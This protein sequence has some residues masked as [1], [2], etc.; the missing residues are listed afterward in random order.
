MTTGNTD[1]AVYFGTREGPEYTAPFA[2]CVTAHFV[3]CVVFC[4]VLCRVCV[5]V[6]AHQVTRGPMAGLG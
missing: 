5:G 2:L 4:A 1:G 6:R 3:R